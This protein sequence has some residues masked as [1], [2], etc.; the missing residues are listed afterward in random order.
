MIVSDLQVTKCAEC[1]CY[2]GVP[3]GFLNDRQQDKRAFYCP[4]GHELSYRQ[5][6][7]EKLRLERDRL[8]QLLA[9]KD[10]E[11]RDLENRRR[12]AVGQ[13][14]RLRNRVGHGV[15]PCCN[16]TFQNLGRHMANE[17]PDFAKEA[18]E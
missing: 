4:N 1:G 17:H 10:D 15:C 12:A 18:A 3:N 13:V 14:T 9:Q 6:E 11:I 5:S 16:R 8:Q 7:A 2:F